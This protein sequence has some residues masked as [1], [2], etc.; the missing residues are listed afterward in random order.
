MKRAAGGLFL[1]VFAFAGYQSW[2]GNGVGTEGGERGMIRGLFSGVN[3]CP[4]TFHEGPGIAPSSC[5]QP[6][7][8][9]PRAE[10]DGAPAPAPSVCGAAGMDAVLATIRQHESGNRYAIGLNAGGASGAY[11]FI[12]GT[13]NATAKRAGRPE[14]ANVYP[15]QASPADQDQLA[16]Q[17]VTEA[18][19]GTD[20]IGRIPVVWYIGHVPGGGEWDTVPHPEAGNRLTPRQYQRKWM[21]TYRGNSG[22]CA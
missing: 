21:D 7:A 16:R 4:T 6:V 1:L 12:R 10:D 11:Q 22:A 17:L 19:G 9:T 5:L 18:L 20:D 14:L 15:Y 3:Q 2:S 8:G 13:W